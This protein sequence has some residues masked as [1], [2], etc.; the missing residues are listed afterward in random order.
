M[1]TFLTSKIVKNQDEKTY[2][3]SFL[4]NLNCEKKKRE[5]WFYLDV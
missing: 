4:Q 3:F 1:L 5:R 2:F